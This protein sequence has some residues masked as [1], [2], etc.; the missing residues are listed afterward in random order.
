MEHI[1]TNF[2]K[3]KNQQQQLQKYWDTK[4][5]LQAQSSMTY[6]KVAT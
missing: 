5:H 1:I 3:K 2:I 4:P 6:I